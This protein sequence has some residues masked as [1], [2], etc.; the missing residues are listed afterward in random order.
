MG[1][2]LTLHYFPKLTSVLNTHLNIEL[3]IS[4]ANR[5]EFTVVNSFVEPVNQKSK[6]NFIAL[7]LVVITVF[8]GIFQTGNVTV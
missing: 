5:R 4:E 1:L 7:F 8:I 2:G 6:I 3:R